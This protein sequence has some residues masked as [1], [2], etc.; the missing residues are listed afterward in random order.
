MPAI[1]ENI[2]G[3]SVSRARAPRKRFGK[4]VVA[5]DRNVL[6]TMAARVV[7]SLPPKENQ[8]LESASFEGP[9]MISKGAF[10][11]LWQ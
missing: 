3:R 9:T 5:V 11:P 2:D 1:Q 10:P 4:Y 8:R 7:I 6:P